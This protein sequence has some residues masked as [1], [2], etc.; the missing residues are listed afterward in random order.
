MPRYGSYKYLM[1]PTEFL[2]PSHSLLQFHE[3][4]QSKGA[5]SNSSIYSRFIFMTFT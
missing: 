4:L 5:Y 1:K 3:I 2:T